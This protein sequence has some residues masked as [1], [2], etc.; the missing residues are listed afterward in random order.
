MNNIIYNVKTDW[1][2]GGD[3]GN[4][5]VLFKNYVDAKNYFEE[6]KQEIKTYDNNYDTIEDT[7]DYY[8]EY[9]EGWYDSGHEL[10]YIEEK[11]LN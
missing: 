1:V 10:V 2:H 6:I 4:S 3:K 9:N 8:E 11:E 7:E 5:D